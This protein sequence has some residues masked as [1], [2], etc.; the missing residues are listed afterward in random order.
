VQLYP[1]PFWRY[2]TAL[3]GAIAA[4]LGA[5]TWWLARRRAA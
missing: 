1:M 5:A 2:V 3:V 4:V